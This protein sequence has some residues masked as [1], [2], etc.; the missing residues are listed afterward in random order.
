E[1]VQ[2]ALHANCPE[3]CGRRR[4]RRAEESP[5]RATEAYLEELANASFKCSTA[6]RGEMCYDLVEWTVTKVLEDP[7]FHA[8]VS[9]AASPE[10]VQLQ[11]HRDRPGICPLPC[12]EGLPH[13]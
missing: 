7:D 3:H 13:Q 4:H 8:G 5:E 9:A 2:K 11:L 12:L 10:Q 1:D 6:K